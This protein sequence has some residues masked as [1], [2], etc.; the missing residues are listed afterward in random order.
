MVKLELCA[1]AVQ[2]PGDQALDIHSPTPGERIYDDADSGEAVCQ[3]KAH[4]ERVWA[5]P[6]C[7][8]VEKVRTRSSAILCQYFYG[9]DNA[10]FN[11]YASVTKY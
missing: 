2:G 4:P 9:I 1:D 10:V 8:A 11:Y 7:C 3:K 5:T 6:I